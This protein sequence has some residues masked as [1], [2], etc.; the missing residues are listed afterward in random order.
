MSTDALRHRVARV[1]DAL[2]ASG[3]ELPR[4]AAELARGFCGVAA[5]H[6]PAEDPPLYDTAVEMMAHRYEHPGAGLGPAW[7]AQMPGPGSW[8]GLAQAM[9]EAWGG[10]AL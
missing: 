1:E 8:H 4:V 3:C 5:L 7:R 9:V 6:E 2:L 10:G